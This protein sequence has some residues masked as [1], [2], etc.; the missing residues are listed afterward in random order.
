MGQWAERWNVTESVRGE[1]NVPQV[2]VLAQDADV[3]DFSVMG[4]KNNKVL[5]C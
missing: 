1:V 2:D 5:K 4:F 3:C